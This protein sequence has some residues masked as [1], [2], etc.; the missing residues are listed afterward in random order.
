MSAL[1][2]RVLNGNKILSLYRLPINFFSDKT[3]TRTIKKKKNE[4]LFIL[5]WN[6][7]K[8]MLLLAAQQT[9]ACDAEHAQWMT[10]RW[11]ARLVPPPR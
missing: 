5:E 11:N 6:I 7:D 10:P 4:F 8:K 9:V 2:K 1:V 3:N